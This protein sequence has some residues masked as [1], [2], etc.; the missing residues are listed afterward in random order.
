MMEN[1]L[2]I[3]LSRQCQLHLFSTTL[4]L[5]ADSTCQST[6]EIH[7]LQG[8]KVCFF[9]LD[10][11]SKHLKTATK[12]LQK[13]WSQ[14]CNWK[15]CFKTSPHIQKGQTINPLVV[16][17]YK[18]RVKIREHSSRC[19]QRTTFTCIFIITSQPPVHEK[20]SSVKNAWIIKQE[21][22]LRQLWQL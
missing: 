2:V 19:P 11:F 10:S 18:S 20:K 4:L 12:K 1:Y 6:D 15:L 3:K 22:N 13:C 5:P 7:G 16:T 21:L 8:L 17:S 14:C 9:K